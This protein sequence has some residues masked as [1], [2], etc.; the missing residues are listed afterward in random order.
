MR[1]AELVQTSVEVS[2]ERGRNAK[3]G[4][5]AE[6]LRQL[7]AEERRVGVA[8]LSGELPQGK[9]GVGW[10]TVRELD[11][12]ASAPEAPSLTLS[13]V[14]AALGRVEEASGSGSAARRRTI[15]GELWA[16]ATEPERTFLSALLR[17]EVRQGAL[18]SVVLEAAA[19]A[20]GV[21]SAAVRRAA[22]LAGSAVEAVTALL[23]GGEAALAHYQLAP[24]RPVLPMLA[25]PTDDAASAI[26]VLG[27]AAFEVKLDGARMQAH[28]D[29]AEVRVYSRSLHDITERV[30][31]VVE[32]ILAL[33]FRRAILDGE[34]IAL[35]PDG[36]PHPFQVSARRF[37]RK[38]AVDELRASLPLTPFVFDALLLDDQVL[39]DAPARERLRALES[40]PAALRA[41]S[42]IT[43][44]VDA[45]ERFYAEVIGR[46][47]EGLMAKS[48]DAPYDA[49][50][51]GSAWLKIKPAHTLDLVVLAVERGS[52]R[53]SGWLSNIH[54]GARD[55]ASPGG[56]A[57]VGK[58]F[59]G[60]TDAM[61]AWQTERF[62]ALA[63]P[64]AL[65]SPWVVEL[66]PEQVVEVALN[67]VQVSTEYA[68][69]VALRFARVRRYRDD[70]PASQVATLAEL[71]ALVKR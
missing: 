50:H 29:G 65:A 37:G 60:M 28:K 46:G 66:A 48:L 9:I 3:I 27:E 55:E 58:T 49:G 34:A 51:R 17:G 21:A 13:E 62:T 53:R 63:R 1:L 4:R 12:S 14:H 39:L 5:L 31:E 18:E 57:M 69:G 10:A 11:N 16:V 54:L 22:M 45:A 7:P 35:K 44:D 20:T 19:Q 70:K 33:P 23:D 24:F 42:L 26:E 52:G 2:R 68:S 47:H 43:A 38:L 40:V 6:L 71:T 30:P 67:D 15:L 25:S 64:G 59:K 8:Y 61:L 41:P 32:H 56:F 36:T